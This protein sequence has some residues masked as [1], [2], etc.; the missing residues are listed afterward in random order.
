MGEYTLLSHAL[1]VSTPT[2][3]G[4]PPLRIET[5]ESL[6]QGLPGN[7]CYYTAWN[8]AG[9]HVDAPAH[10]LAGGR[11]ILEVCINDL[12]YDRPLIVDVP[13]E[14]DQLVTPADLRSYE[15]AIA[16]SDLLLLRTGFAQYRDSDPVRYRDRNPGLSVDAARYLNATRFPL[17]LAV[18][19]DTI[20]MA[21]ASHV[22]EGV[23][24]HK[25]LFAREDGSSI[26]LLEDMR[27]APD[28]E[29][30][31]R[32]FVVPLFIEGLDSSPCTI[33]A[34]IDVD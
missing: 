23:E 24:A 33:V 1:S 30:L 6:D 25:I 5:D 12:I 32:V 7:T 16:E 3:G 18:G 17:L 20:S 13:K 27:L 9:T 29:R 8:H 22:A 31:T 28:L 15:K 14:D 26:L 19:I 10:M 11:T 34:E 4:R 2:P 21:A